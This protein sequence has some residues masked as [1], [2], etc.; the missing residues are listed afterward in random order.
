MELLN[1]MRIFSTV[2]VN[3]PQKKISLYVTFHVPT[4]DIIMTAPANDVK[5]L[6]S[7]HLLALLTSNVNCDCNKQF[8][9]PQTDFTHSAPTTPKPRV[10][11]PSEDFRQHT[12]FSV[13]LTRP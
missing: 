10:F 7:G 2:A 5:G 13:V 3:L 1:G 6:S 8:D 9:L 11:L 4:S 12:A